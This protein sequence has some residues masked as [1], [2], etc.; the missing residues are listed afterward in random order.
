VQ[1]LR[2]Y[3]IVPSD[4]R[5]LLMQREGEGEWVAQ[6]RFGLEPHVVADYAEMCRYHQTSPDSH[7]TR[8]KVCSVATGEGRVTLSGTRLITTVG[9]AKQER[10]LSGKQEYANALREHFGVVLAG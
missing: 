5:L 4:D 3:R 2:A 9:R 1:G 10:E 6:Y 8:R 7:F